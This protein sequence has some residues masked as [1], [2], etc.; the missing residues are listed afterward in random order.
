MAGRKLGPEVKV[1][2]FV[3]V[4]SYKLKAL[5]EA[6]GESVYQPKKDEK[7]KHEELTSKQDNTSTNNSESEVKEEG[8]E[9][10]DN[11]TKVPGE[12]EEYQTN[13]I[14]KRRGGGA[15]LDERRKRLRKLWLNL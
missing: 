9:S 2:E 15:S 1:R 5:E 3:L 14:R 6:G 11:E 8:R 10:L 12:S 4:P 13:G 7:Q